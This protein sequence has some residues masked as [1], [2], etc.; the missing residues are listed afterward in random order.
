MH[1]GQKIESPLNVF[2]L[3]Q[4]GSHGQLLDRE[5][6]S[7]QFDAGH[8]DSLQQKLARLSDDLELPLESKV[9]GTLPFLEFRIGSD[10]KGA[11]VLYYFHDEIILA[12]LLLTG[13]DDQAEQELT[14]VFRFLLLDDDDL[15]NPTEQ[16]I[17]E[18]LSSASFDFQQLTSRPAVISV[19]LA[20]EENETPE[21]LHSQKINLHLAAVFFARS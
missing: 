17:V 4:F 2:T 7:I 14:E 1:I 15:E 16:Q 12:S 9:P 21:F 20:T 3:F 11:F 19:A 10:G 5:L 6:K 13:E 8:L 18:I